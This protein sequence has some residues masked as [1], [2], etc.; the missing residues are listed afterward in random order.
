MELQ[1]ALTNL[2]EY[3]NLDKTLR[4]SNKEEWNDFDKFCDSHCEDIA[5]VLHY[6]KEESIPRAKVEKKIKVIQE[7]FKEETRTDFL[8]TLKILENELQE[9]LNKGE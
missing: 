8:I 5:T 4:S 1:K 6:I 9:I 3:I 2:E 7:K